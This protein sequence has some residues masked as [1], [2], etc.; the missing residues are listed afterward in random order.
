MTKKV[1][2]I[3]LLG[4]FCCLGVSAQTSNS[5]PFTAVTPPPPPALTTLGNLSPTGKIYTGQVMPI[6][7]TGFTAS[8]VVNVDGTAQPSSTFAFSS[9]TLINFTVPASLGS[10]AGTSHTLTVSCTTPA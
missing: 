4:L 8:C 10:S 3:A 9:A 1:L 5:L 7:G 6:N 2:A